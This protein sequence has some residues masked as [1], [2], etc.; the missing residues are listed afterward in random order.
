MVWTRTSSVR[1]NA[2][3]AFL[4]PPPRRDPAVLRREPGVL[5]APDGKAAI[6]VRP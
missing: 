2:T 4:L 5:G 1:I 3:R 6:R